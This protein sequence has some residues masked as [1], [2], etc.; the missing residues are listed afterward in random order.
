MN[1][2]A[3]IILDGERP[4]RE[5]L[6][7]YWNRSIFRICADGASATCLA[8]RL[9]PDLIIGDLDSI[10]ADAIDRFAS[11]EMIEDLDQDTTD[12]EKAIQY[13]VDK[14]FRRLFVL[15]A[16]GKRLDHGVYNLG[17][18]RKYHDQ[19]DELLLV[20]EGETAFLLSG[21]RS[22]TAPIGTRISLLPIFGPAENVVSEGLEY[23]IAGK[24]MELGGFT[25]VSNAFS[26]PQAH[27][28]IDSGFLLVILGTRGSDSPV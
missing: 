6:M 8:Y 15:G 13:C 9:E 21:K 19:V 1:N 22:F 2:A 24:T 14:G 26:R 10:G 11:I 4:P 7:T 16:L 20:S 23:A 12:S 27:I 17:L 5:T 25:S 28:S 3:L 18:L